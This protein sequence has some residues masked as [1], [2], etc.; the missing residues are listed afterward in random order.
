MENIKLNADVGEGIGNDVALMP[1]LTY[2]NIACGG[3]VGDENSIK[4]TIK[5]AKINNVKIGAHPSYP[6]KENFGRKSMSFDFIELEKIIDQQIDVFLN[7]AKSLKVSMHHIKLH[8]ALY[9]DVFTNET[10]TQWFLNYAFE[11]YK[12]VKIFVPLGAKNFV[13]SNYQN[14]VIY[15]AFVDRNYNDKLQLVSRSQP[16]A[17]IENPTE[18]FNHVQYLFVENKLI[19]ITGKLHM[20][21]A[22]T[23]CLHGDNPKVLAIAKEIYQLKK[24]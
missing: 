16:N 7:I 23:F 9:N 4:E 21:T 20:I 15:E 14:L 2:A 1:F 22:D 11:K 12:G 19:S 10:A 13:E 5:L 18:A 24:Q 6:D 17:S 8:G 3:H